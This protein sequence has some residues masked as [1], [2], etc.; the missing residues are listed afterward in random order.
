[1]DEFE[2]SL[3]LYAIGDIH[4]QL[5]MLRELH[6]IIERYHRRYYRGWRGRLVYIG[7]Y[8]DRGPSSRGVI[9]C[10]RQGLRGF[11]SVF[12]KGNHEVMM[13]HCLEVDSRDAWLQWVTNGGEETLN[14]FDYP[15]GQK[16]I[17]RDLLRQCVGAERID[18]LSSLSPTYVYADYL[19]VHAGLRPGVK[20]EKQREQDLLWIRQPFLKYKKDFGHLVV[21]GHTPVDE[22]EVLP[23][24][25]DIDTGAGFN[26][27][28]TAL[29][30][31]RP[32]DELLEHPV[33][34][35]VKG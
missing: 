14:S 12:L 23:N 33:F 22:P 7:D 8:I 16:G 17:D 31:D 6:R 21:H 15:L 11:D 26:R 30:I 24:R 5:D 3:V 1:M 27:K 35:T 25:I 2:E 4:G 29:V 19:F 32:A 18:W 10:V 9:D 34:I 28:L 13:M 20:L